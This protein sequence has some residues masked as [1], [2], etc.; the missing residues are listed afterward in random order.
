MTAVDFEPLLYERLTAADLRDGAYRRFIYAAAI[1]PGIRL[2][3]SRRGKHGDWPYPDTKFNPNTGLDLSPDCYS[4]IYSWMIGRGLEA[5]ND[6]LKILD[7]LDLPEAAAVEAA[8]K[9]WTAA[10]REFIERMAASNENRCPFLVDR[11]LQPLDAELQPAT[12][13]PS[14][15]GAGDVFCAKGLLSS[16]SASARRRGLE[17]LVAAAAKVRDGRYGSEQF[18]EVSQW[19]HQGMKMLFLGAPRLVADLTGDDAEEIKQQVFAIAVEFMGFVLE[20]HYDQQ[21]GLFSEGIDP[22][23]GEHSGL[24]DP[25]HCTE[26]VGLALS[27]MDSIERGLGE[28]RLPE[29]WRRC[30][31]AARAAFPRMLLTAFRLGYNR[32]Q[33][34]MCKEVNT[35]TGEILNADM[36]WWNLPETMRAAARLLPFAD[37]AGEDCLEVIRLCHNAYFSHYL[38]RDLMLFPFQTRCGLTG[39]VKDV[40]P[41]VPEGDPLYHSN[42]SFIDMLQALE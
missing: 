29:Q 34:G 18:P 2:L 35:R 33:G 32:Q 30:F 36:P 7:E 27:A 3:L 11:S 6:H 40:V 4:R 23:T 21:T 39:A 41:A 12:I 38:N 22:V 31:A 37:T 10:Q 26:F 8:F 13:D 25:G 19:L 14:R 9:Q 28:D 24:L 15:A 1:I 17:M 42:L 16:S 20:H 5:L